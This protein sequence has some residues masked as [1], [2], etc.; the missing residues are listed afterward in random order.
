MK[1]LT[2]EEYAKLPLMGRGR[3]SPFYREVA[4]LE[5]NEILLLEKAD[6]KKKYHPRAVVRNLEKRTGRKHEVL[7]VIT[8]EGWTVKRVR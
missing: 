3:M 5:V 1:R 2:P 4:K 6:W 7:T 8:G